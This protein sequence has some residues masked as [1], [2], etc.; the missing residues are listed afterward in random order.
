VGSRFELL[1]VPGGYFQLARYQQISSEGDVAFAQR[2][3][4]EAGVAVVPVSAF[5]H[6]GRDEGLIRFCFAKQDHTLRAAAER[7]RGL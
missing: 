4:R 7:L 3:T 6:D 1:P 5:Y 2:L